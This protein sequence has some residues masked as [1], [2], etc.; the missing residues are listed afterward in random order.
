MGLSGSLSYNTISVLI[1]SSST[2]DAIVLQSH[3]IAEKDAHFY[4]PAQRWEEYIF[5]HMGEQ[6]CVVYTIKYMYL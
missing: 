4:N 5:S 6:L 3:H 1:K 2:H